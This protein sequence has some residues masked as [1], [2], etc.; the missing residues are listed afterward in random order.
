MYCSVDTLYSIHPKK[1]EH[2]EINYLDFSAVLYLYF[3][4]FKDIHLDI[5]KSVLYI[6]VFT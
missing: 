1:G 6:Y 5:H 2:C 3:D 4:L